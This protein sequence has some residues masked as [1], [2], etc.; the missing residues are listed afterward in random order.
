M[1]LLGSSRLLI[2][3]GLTES[4][5]GRFET[6]YMGHWGFSEMQTAFGF[7][8]EQYAWF[9]GYPAAAG[10]IEDEIRWKDYI[11][12]SL[13]ETTVSKDILLIDRINKPALLRNLFEMGCSFSGQILSFNKILGQLHD[14]GNTTT[15]LHYLQLLNNQ[16]CLL[17]WRNFLRAKLCNVLQAQNF[18]FKILHCLVPWLIIFFQ[19]Q[20]ET[21]KFGEGMLKLQLEFIC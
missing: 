3:K 16:A 20:L 4:L 12:N 13:M 18:L 5:A 17:D 11:L 9:G 19:K 7:N 6:I 21:V 1:V 15:L 14:A 2:Q 8:E 10:L